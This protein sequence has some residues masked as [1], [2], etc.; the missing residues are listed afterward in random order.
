MNQDKS[1]EVEIPQ[2]PRIFGW[3][4]L[5]LKKKKTFSGSILSG[6]ELSHFPQFYE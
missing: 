2:Y 6:W 4:L 5:S 3:K 1:S